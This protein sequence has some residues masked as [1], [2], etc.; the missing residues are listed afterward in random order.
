MVMA[1]GGGLQQVQGA[2]LP[3]LP[4]FHPHPH[5]HPPP[6]LGTS[7]PCRRR[8]DKLHP[9][10]AWHRGRARVLLP[11]EAA[12]ACV[13]ARRGGEGRKAT[14]SRASRDGGRMRTC[15]PLGAPQTR[16]SQHKLQ[17]FVVALPHRR[18]GVPLPPVQAAL[19]HQGDTQQT[20]VLVTAHRR[21]GISP[22]SFQPWP[23]TLRQ[24]VSWAFEPA[25]DAI[26]AVMIDKGGWVGG[27]AGP[28]AIR[29]CRA[30]R[31]RLGLM[32][33]CF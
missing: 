30:A 20:H 11:L 2:Y 23:Y 16:H 32:L 25:D 5:P 22:D 1:G 26:I 24:M 14:A 6:P 8:P 18:A 3:T 10:A 17:R 29:P 31:P 9:A 7:A 28:A 13:Q 27:Q 33:L 21:I 19:A 12:V 4:P 15:R